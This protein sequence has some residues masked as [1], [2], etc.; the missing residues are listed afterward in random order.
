M[1]R[2][3]LKLFFIWPNNNGARTRFV[4]LS[5]VGVCAHSHSAPSPMTHI[6]APRIQRIFSEVGEKGQL[7]LRILLIHPSSLYAFSYD[8]HFHSAPFP[9]AHIVGEDAQPCL[10]HS[11]M[12]LNDLNLVLAP[13][14]VVQMKKCSISFLSISEGT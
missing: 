14:I 6:F 4:S 2:K 13:L 10:E 9:T 8:A 11:P 12:A 5:A 3:D 7:I 1:E